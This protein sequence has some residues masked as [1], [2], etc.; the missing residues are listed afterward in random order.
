MIEIPTPNEH[1]MNAH[2]D[3]AEAG[4]ERLSMEEVKHEVI[5]VWEDMVVHPENL[6]DLSERN[7][8][9]VAGGGLPSRFGL[10]EG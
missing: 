6:T 2:P 5:R 3:Q 10:P 1:D 9:F 7:V 8:V 4:S